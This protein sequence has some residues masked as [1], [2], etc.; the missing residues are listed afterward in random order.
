MYVLLVAE[1][2]APRSVV[3]RDGTPVVLRCLQPSDRDRLAQAYE[4]LSEESRRR[5]FFSPPKHL[6][7]GF[8]D[9]LT[10]I[11]HDQR[12]AWVA[13]EPHAPDIGLG[14]ARWVRNR[15]DSSRAEPA[16]AVVD[17]WQGRGL[18]TELLLALI[19]VAK[20]KGIGTFVAEVLWENKVILDPLKALGA[21][22]SPSEPGIALVEFDLPSGLDGTALH[23]LLSRAAA[24][25]VSD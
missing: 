21:R 5:R 24:A 6:S 17:D 25:R 19:D 2:E 12:F 4:V 22:V 23:H 16:V 14:L 11:D 18:G 1:A 3:L 20:T 15:D 13:F 10:D 8:L 7:P 9:Y